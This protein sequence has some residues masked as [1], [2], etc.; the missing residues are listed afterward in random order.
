MTTTRDLVLGDLESELDKT[1]ILLESVPDAHFDW[2]PHEKSWHIGALA[3]HLANLLSWH[4]TVL[5]T[6]GL[7]LA[8]LPPSPEPPSEMA[9]VLARYEENRRELEA[10]VAD[11]TDDVLARTWTLRMGDRTMMS[12]PRAVAFREMCVSHAAH[13]RG[14]LTVYLRLLDVPVPQTFGPTADDQGG[15]G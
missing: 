11:V 3:T 9:S 15:F 2:K 1:R 5:T 4:T 6:D 8:T 13:H 12:A 7:D 10:A 14:Q